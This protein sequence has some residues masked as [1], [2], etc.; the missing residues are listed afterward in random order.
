MITILPADSGEAFEQ[1]I[2]LANEYVTWMVGEI[3]VQYPELDLAE[4]ISEHSYDDLR[5]KFPGDQVPP[6][7]GLLIAEHDGELAGCIALG[8]L[9]DTIGE[10]R[11]LFVRPAFRG[12]GAGRAL[13]AAVLDAACEAE[14]E[15]V[16][17]DTLGFMEGAQALYQSFGFAPIPPYLDLPQSLRQYIRFLELP[18]ASRPGSSP[19]P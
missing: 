3:A 11:T 9:S 2:T 1:F 8:P 18:L 15:R 16:R 7:G 6:R 4:F 13:V 5:R 14:Y 12:A 10:V 17:L 19:M